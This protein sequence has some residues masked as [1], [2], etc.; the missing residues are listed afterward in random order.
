MGMG[1][2]TA[3]QHTYR[4]LPGR[5]RRVGALWTAARHSLWLG[6][7]HLLK[8]ENRF[9]SEEYRRFYY[10]DIQTIMVRRTGRWIVWNVIFGV[11]C[12][13][14]VLL[15]MPA[16][17]P[18]EQSIG[19]S[20][21]GLCLLAILLNT[22]YGPTCACHLRTA[23]QTVALPS[24]SRRR[25]V[26]QALDLLQPLIVQAQGTLTPD[27]LAAG[28]ATA[29]SAAALPITPGQRPLSSPTTLRQFRG[30]R[31]ALLFTFL[32]CDGGVTLLT[33]LGDSPM[34]LLLT[35]VIMLGAFVTTLLALTTQQ[36]SH[37]PQGLRVVTWGAGIYVCL[38]YTAR[39][40]PPTFL[41]L[42]DPNLLMAN[43]FWEVLM[44][45]ATQS[46]HHQSY[47]YLL[48]SISLL[49]SVGLGALGWLCLAGLRRRRPVPPPL[50]LAPTPA[51]EE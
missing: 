13:G 12:G 36:Q 43:S 17:E 19:A 8:V 45:L 32:L 33:L 7:D 40:I 16:G 25:H 1:M 50:R 46:P 18:V 29:L 28:R 42:K 39:T 27:M 35:W 38:L 26:H 10:R 44:L 34:A 6:A 4:R 23:V 15:S 3:P 48:S 30:G 21:A 5:R 22:L 37:C 20:L 14:S 24:W 11:L 51:L 49:C 9:Y 41:T 47:M 31:H 2:M